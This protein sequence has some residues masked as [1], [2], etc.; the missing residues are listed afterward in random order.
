M[1]ASARAAPLR[2]LA[3]ALA[4]GLILAGC[5]SAPRPAAVPAVPWSQQRLRLQGLDPFEMSGRVAVAAGSEGFTAHLSWEQHGPRSTLELNGPLGIGAMRVVAEG[6]R[7]NVETSKGEKLASDEARTELADKLGFDPPLASLRYWVLGVPDP[8]QPSIET[9]GADQRLA[10][11]EQDGWQ[12]VYASYMSAGGAT[13]L[14]Q[15]LTLLRG[16]VRVR[17]IVDHWQA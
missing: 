8:A 5:V 17:L 3:A 7:L 14:P 1:R 9:V 16:D 15:R 12:I 10:E 13:W 11:L 4:A 6:E 2:R